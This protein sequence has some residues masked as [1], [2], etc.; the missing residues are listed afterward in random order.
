[1]KLA[2]PQVKPRVWT[3]FVKRQL[4]VWPVWFTSYNIDGI[5]SN[6]LISLKPWFCLICL[7]FLIFTSSQHFFSYIGTG[8][9][10]FKQY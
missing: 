10:G 7:Y 6:M 2:R 4:F 1:M 5:L 8:L 9:P 3:L